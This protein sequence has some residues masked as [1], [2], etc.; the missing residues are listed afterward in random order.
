MY[1]NIV[2][3]L[4][5]CFKVYDTLVFH[6]QNV[7]RVAD[8]ALFLAIFRLF[9][10]HMKY[11]SSTL[12][13]RYTIVIILYHCWM[14]Q[15]TIVII[16]YHC[17][18]DQYTIVIILYHCWMDQYT[19]VIILYH[20]WMDQYT[21]VIILYRCWMDQYTIVIILYHCWMDQYTIV[22]ILYH[23][24]MDQYTILYTVPLLDGSIYHTIYCTIAG[25]INI[26]YHILYHC[27]M[28]QYTILYTV[29]LLDGSIYHTIHLTA[30]LIICTS[31][32]IVCFYYTRSNPHRVCFRT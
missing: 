29:P 30:V 12:Y 1:C 26:R 11:V 3:T 5:T 9:T 15:Y 4:Y 23:C 7:N 19:I 27:W 13:M 20:C 28:D 21:I 24:W 8:M 25:W 17:W 16:L 2:N 6:L 10:I 18:M 14:D 22:I 32:I 31:A